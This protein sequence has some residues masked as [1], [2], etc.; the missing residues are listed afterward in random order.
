[1]LGGKLFHCHLASKW[2][3]FRVSFTVMTPN[4]KIATIATFTFFSSN[5]FIYAYVYN[6]KLSR[7]SSFAQNKKRQAGFP[8]WR[9]VSL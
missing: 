7:G 3:T 1:M 6:L 9:S 8:V 2:Y 5:K 4:N